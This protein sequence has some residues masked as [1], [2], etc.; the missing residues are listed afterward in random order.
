MLGIDAAPFVPLPERAW[1]D[2]VHP[3]DLPATKRAL[4]E[5]LATGAIFRASYR[6]RTGSE[7][8][9]ILSLGRA[10]PG[11]CGAPPRVVGLNLQLSS[12]L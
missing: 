10:L 11:S 4:E 6:A 1:E 8:R 5:A 3:E 2:S 9:W 12:A 7:E